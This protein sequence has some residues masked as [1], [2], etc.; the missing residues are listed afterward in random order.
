MNNIVCVDG[1]QV[2]NIGS[3]N[4][5][6]DII[7]KFLQKV[8]VLLVWDDVDGVVIIYGIDMF[9]EIVYFFN[10]IVKSDKLVVFIVVMWF[11]LVISVDGVMNLLEVVMVVVDLNV[12]GCGVMVVL[13]D[14]IGLVCFVMKI[15]VMILDIFKV[16]EEGYLGVIV[17][18]Q[19]QFE[20]WVEKIYILCF[21]FDVCNI[22]KLFN[23]VIIYG[24]Q[25]DLEYMYDVVIVYYVDG[26]IYVGIG[27]GLVLVCSDVGIKKVEKVGIIVVCVFCIGNGVVLLDKGQSGLVFDLFNLV[28]V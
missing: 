4:M 16:L 9:D 11:V 17:N 25:D 7:L 8:N 13:N 23:V 18:G 22:K 28:K 2:V 15:N 24:Y 5:I 6:S 20:M 10:L 26:I 27:V 21:V 14:C 1:E 12:K 3:E 19:L